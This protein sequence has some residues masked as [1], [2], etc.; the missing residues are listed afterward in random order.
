MKRKIKTWLAA[1]LLGGSILLS[2]CDAAV[3]GFGLIAGAA[4]MYYYQKHISEKKES[5]KKE[6]ITEKEVEE[7][8]I[9]E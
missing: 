9:I 6:A 8:V 1:A 5:P 7:G 3:L 2:G 4:G